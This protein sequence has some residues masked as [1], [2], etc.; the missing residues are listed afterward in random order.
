MS[1]RLVGMMYA[2]NGDTLQGRLRFTAKDRL[3]FAASVD[4]PVS[5]AGVYDLVLE[6]GRY[7]VGYSPDNFSRFLSVGE[8][9]IVNGAD[10][11]LNQ[12]LVN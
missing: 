4:H 6:N 3:L 10:T 11:T 8:I 7:Q 5:V 12:L 2:P 9:T 1:R